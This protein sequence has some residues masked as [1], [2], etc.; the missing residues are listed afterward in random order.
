MTVENL[1]QNNQEPSNF[2]SDI[3]IDQV[4]SLLDCLMLLCQLNNVAMTRDALTS[5]LPLRNGKLTPVLFKRAAERA[6][7]VS[8]IIKKPLKAISSEFLPAVLL[9][10]DEEACV[11]LGWD[12]SRQNARVIFPELGETEV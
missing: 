9:L 1:L 2:R 7:L 11:L 8:K 12:A 4:D 3:T 10:A 6:N 5:G